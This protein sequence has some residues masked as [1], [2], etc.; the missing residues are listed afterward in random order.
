MGSEGR[1][2]VTGGLQTGGDLE[3]GTERGR[4]SWGCGGRCGGRDCGV[5][6]GK[7]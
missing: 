2:G 4:G 5:G 1:D 3:V 6:P 7:P